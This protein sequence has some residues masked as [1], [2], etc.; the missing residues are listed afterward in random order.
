[1]RILPIIFTMSRARFLS[2]PSSGPLEQGVP[3]TGKDRL[4]DVWRIT[5]HILVIASTVRCFSVHPTAIDV[6]FT[7]RLTVYFVLPA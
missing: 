6:P 4:Q 7:L 5:V 1:M 2:I 3:E